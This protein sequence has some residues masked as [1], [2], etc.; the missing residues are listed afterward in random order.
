MTFLQSIM[1][2][3]IA[4]TAYLFL[5]NIF[6]VVSK[7]F[8]LKDKVTFVVSFS[9]NNKS[10]YKE[11]MRQELSCRTIFLATDKMYSGFS[12]LPRAETLL[13]NV[14]KPMDFIRSIFH[15]ATSRI[16]FVDNYYGFLSKAKFKQEVECIQ[17]WH[18][19]GAIK[20]FGLEDPSVLRRSTRAVKRFK[21]VY[22]RFTKVT[23]GS[24]A[25]A[26]IFKKAFGLDDSIMWRTGIP[27]T[28]VFFDEKTKSVLINKVYT[29]YSIL[30]NK[31]VILYAPTYRE[32]GLKNPK[33]GL[34]LF[35]LHKTLGNDYVLMVKFHPAVQSQFK[36][37]SE[38]SQFV[39]DVSS[40]RNVNELLFISDLLI[41][42]YS[43]IPFEYSL[44]NRPIIFYMHDL[45][46]YRKERGMWQ[47]FM[48]FLPGP[49]VY[50]FDELINE[51]KNPTSN[52]SDVLA[53][54][55]KWNRYSTGDASQ[56]IVEFIK[57]KLQG[58]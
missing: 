2:R 41:T 54:S 43:S 45:E 5:F 1:V 15:L 31:K 37:P 46:D 7:F 4:I 39:I 10:I 52:S 49:I 3:E 47:E 57:T 33:V 13:F 28:D 53:F 17:L 42:D 32:S 8:P 36:V 6:F 16:V 21:H 24:D 48:E 18:A 27:R 29:K 38:L 40:H 34:D 51:I 23:I 58:V 50:S 12:K 14:R 20:K 55:D 19:N 30:Y 56:R 35:K 9:E 11:M 44:L 26:S 25:M 22:N